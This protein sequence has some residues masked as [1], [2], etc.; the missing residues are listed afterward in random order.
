MTPG[1]SSRRHRRSRPPHM[2][3]EYTD[4]NAG[5][6]SVRLGEDR[7]LMTQECLQGFMTPDMMCITD[8]DGR[9]LQGTRS[10]DG[11]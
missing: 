10:V 4:A 9:K 5:N 8:L 3:A 2:P 6:I 7:L 11:C 1:R